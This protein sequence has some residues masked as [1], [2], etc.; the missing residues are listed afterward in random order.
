MAFHP[1]VVDDSPAMR[2]FIIRVIE[3]SGLD[4]ETCV[5]ASNGQEALDL[6]RQ[7]WIDIVLT[8]INMPVMNGEEFV[9]LM[10]ADE[11]LR[12][13][14][15]LVVSTDG[16]V[17]RVEKMMSLGAKAY[18]KKP[19]SP[20]LLRKSMEDLLGISVLGVNNA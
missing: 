4:V 17:H 10:E 7:N 12:T 15:V 6:L 20:E 3:L 11:V 1:M 9:R 16:S 18:V 2:A 14:P 8:D 19:F 13:I 5:Q